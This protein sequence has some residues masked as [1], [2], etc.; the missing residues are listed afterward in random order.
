MLITAIT[1]LISTS[2]ALAA[3]GF[4][5]N[6]TAPENIEAVF[7]FGLDYDRLADIDGT[8]YGAF[9]STDQWD[10]KG[11]VAHTWENSGTVMTSVSLFYRV[12]ESGTTPPSFS[13]VSLTGS[14]TLTG[15]NRSWYVT[16]NTIDLLSGLTSTGNYVI[17]MYYEG[18]TNTPSTEYWSNFGSNYIGTFSYTAALPVHL[19]DF[20]AYLDIDVPVLEWTTASELNA[21]HFNVYSSLDGI[22]KEYLGRVEANGTLI[23]L[24]TISM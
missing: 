22:D 13:S 7:D 5:E 9:V 6:T 10:L 12:Y 21:S 3:A 4:Y 15:G 2:S 17:E 1:L 14:T 8:N 16:S 11:G 19:I 24:L 23:V 20:S 18:Y